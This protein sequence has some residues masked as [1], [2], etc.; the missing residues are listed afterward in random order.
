MKSIALPEILT[1]LLRSTA[2]LALAVWF[3][4]FTFY[5]GVVIPILHDELGGMDSGAITGMVSKPLNWIGV[6]ALLAGWIV[7]IVERKSQPG[8]NRWAKWGRWTLLIATTAI[9]TFLIALHPVVEGRLETA[10]LKDFH[11]MH[12]VYLIASTIQWCINVGLI[13]SFL[14]VWQTERTR[15]EPPMNAD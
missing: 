13:A 3:G 15:N 6:G 12:Q 14:M 5:A 8:W 4:G 10:S 7:A 1:L 2:I 11:R 9:L